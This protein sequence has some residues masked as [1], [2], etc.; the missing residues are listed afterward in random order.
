M[1]EARVTQD[2][3][4]QISAIAASANRTEA[5]IVRHA[6]TQYLGQTDPHSVKGAIADLQDRV[7][8]LE[9]KLGRLAG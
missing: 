8:N 4:L 3:K 7:I 6:I 9:R 5:E 1:V 2:F